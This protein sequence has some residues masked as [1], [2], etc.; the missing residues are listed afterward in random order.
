M[1]LQSLNKLASTSSDAERKGTDDSDYRF[2]RNI[3]SSK[4]GPV[5]DR[6]GGGGSA[7][8]DLLNPAWLD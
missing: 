4:P 6:Q 3:L 1:G 2:G 7:F 5:L 8:F